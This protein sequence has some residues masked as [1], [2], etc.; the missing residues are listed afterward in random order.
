[1]SLIFFTQAIE[2]DNNLLIVT[3]TL[4][5]TVITCQPNL[6]TGMFLTIKENHIATNQVILCAPK[7][8]TLPLS[9]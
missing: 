6:A 9:I 1:M 2:F 4:T 5:C 8:A 3:I 7:L